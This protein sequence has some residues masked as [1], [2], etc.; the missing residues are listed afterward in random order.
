MRID[1]AEFLGSWERCVDMPHQTQPEFAFIGRSNVGKSS[2]INML[3]ER[4]GLAKTSSTPGKTQTLNLFRINET[5]Q[6]CDLPGYGYAKV[7]KKTREK[8]GKMIGFYLKE[9]PNLYCL[10]V[11]LDLRLPPQKI[12]LDFIADCGENQIPMVLVGTKADKLKAAELEQNV[13]GLKTA[14]LEMWEEI[15]PL[16]IS[17]SEDKRGR[18]EIWQTVQEAMNS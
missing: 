11:L 16:I 18:D 10:F 9:R 1:K 17:S 15:P 8:F 7:S 12:D 14:L 6:I 4:K 5:L 13:E 3:C 2:L